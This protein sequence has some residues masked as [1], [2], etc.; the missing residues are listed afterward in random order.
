MVPPLAVGLLSAAAL[1]FEVFL[2]RA[3]SIREWYHFAALII[4]LALLGYGA[5]GTV[6]S[7]FHE[8]LRARPRMIFATA[9]AGFAVS[10]LACFSLAQAVPLTLIEMLW[11]PEQALR[12]ILVATVLAVPFFCAAS[13]IGL[14]IAGAG[15]QV[16]RVYRADL[17]GAAVGALGILGLMFVTPPA[18][19]LRLISLCGL[20]AAATALVIGSPAR[21]R[22]AR[23]L[24]LA[25]TVLL[26]AV[27]PAHWL[28]PQTSPYKELSQSLRIP[29]TRIIAERH[30]PYGLLSVVES[31]QVPFRFAPGLS[32]MTSLEP[33]EQKAV[34][35]DGGGMT[36][37]TR[38]DGRPEALAYLDQQTAALPFHLVDRPKVLVLGL[39]GGADVLLALFHQAE[40]ITAAELNPQMADLL[41][42]GPLA[43]FAG[44]LDRRPEVR[45]EVAEARSFAA[46]TD[47]R[48][49][50]IQI[51]LL[52]SLAAAASGLNAMNETALYTVE[53]L[54]LYLDR[55]REGGLLALTRW[56]T[57]PPR[58]TLKLLVTAATAL[59]R[60]GSTSPAA[61]LALVYGW[62]T[63]TL[64]VGRTPLSADRLARVR[65]FAAERG[66]DAGFLPGLE[67]SETGRFTPLEPPGLFDAATL[68][69][70][71]ERQEFLARYKFNIAPATD[72]RPYFF[73]FLKP[74]T[75]LEFARMPERAGLNLIDWG[76]PVLL[77]TIGQALIASSILITL[78]LVFAG[79]RLAV[80]VRRRPRFSLLTLVYFSALGLGFLFIEI[81]WM[82]RLQL[83]FGQPLIA[84][85]VTIAGFL[86]FAGLGSGASAT[87]TARW[88]LAP[89]VTAAIAAAVVSAF[90]VIAALNLDRLLALA[91]PWPM[92]LKLPLAIMTLAPV[93]FAMGMPFPSGVRWL[94][95]KELAMV[96]W[97]WGINGCASVLSAALATLIAVHAGI[98]AVLAA[99]AGLYLAAAVAIAVARSPALNARPSSASR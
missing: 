70:G 46:G 25:G 89:A 21:I 88:P 86:L 84:V 16:G 87:L 55:L 92:A 93:A 83:F 90:A 64:V 68:L 39:G 35:T 75:L 60:R 45:I 71:P 50:I 18:D 76:Y 9:A 69:L 40:Q 79:R 43:A 72:D 66:F 11:A 81:A 77:A 96:P 29:G 23:S 17:S 48:F 97:A 36:A 7:F 20:I 2:V 56:L 94:A 85:A 78:P 27:W 31:P 13:A 53:A 67:R 58:D 82:Q 65:A 91:G 59:E 57:V 99:A 51:A 19:S 12:L 42:M 73:Q 6:L 98:A 61:H 62:Q 26:I 32:L 33:P 41:R 80:Q 34:F 10:T 52:D 63:A 4:G 95:A 8:R 38:F 22:A 28:T 3:F 15:A 47:Q 49:D 37:I 30:S 5:S 1:A 54:E 14:A 24:L 74:A 44:D